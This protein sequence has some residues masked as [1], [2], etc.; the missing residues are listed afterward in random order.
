MQRSCEN[1]ERN[2][3]W[4]KMGNLN[5]AEQETLRYKSKWDCVWKIPMETLTQPCY[6]PSYQDMWRGIKLNSMTWIIVLQGL[7]YLGQFPQGMTTNKLFQSRQAYL[8][9][10]SLIDCHKCTELRGPMLPLLGIPSAQP[11][12]IPFLLCSASVPVSTLQRTVT[13]SNISSGCRFEA[14]CLSPGGDSFASLLSEHC[15]TAWEPW[16]WSWVTL[17]VAELW[18]QTK[19]VNSH[20]CSY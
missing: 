11:H 5:Q 6:P 16:V 20:L 8:V 4:S 9:A 19:H 7:T 15:R 2:Q 12:V 14:P 17:A 1:L 10:P 13:S 3:S 18:E